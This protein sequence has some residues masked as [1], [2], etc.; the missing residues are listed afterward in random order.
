MRVIV[1]SLDIHIQ[2]LPPH[3]VIHT[4]VNYLAT[5]GASGETLGTYAG[6]LLLVRDNV[7]LDS[8]HLVNAQ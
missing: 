5:A 2:V 7:N 3:L 6:W 1:R 4:P 8:G